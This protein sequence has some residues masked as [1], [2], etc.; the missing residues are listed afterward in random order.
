MKMN[1][2]LGS[3]SLAAVLGVIVLYLFVSYVRAANLHELYMAQVKNQTRALQKEIVDAPIE[4]P[5]EVKKVAVV[6]EE[7][8]PEKK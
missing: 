5:V 6:P 7:K 1:I 3:K 2:S 4:K 8:C